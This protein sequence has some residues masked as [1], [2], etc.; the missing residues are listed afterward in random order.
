M[1][2]ADVSFSFFRV[3][4]IETRL[5]RGGLKS[6]P[7]LWRLLRITCADGH[8]YEIEAQALNAHAEYVTITDRDGRATPLAK[9]A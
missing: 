7:T 3:T 6:R 5:L 8:T 4:R 9:G 2:D 1:P